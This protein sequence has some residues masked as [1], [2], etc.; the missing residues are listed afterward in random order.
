MDGVLWMRL[1]GVKPSVCMYIHQVT[2]NITAKAKKHKIVTSQ[3][4][5]QSYD[6]FVRRLVGARA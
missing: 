3:N 2:T 5:V 6:L 4:A 1:N